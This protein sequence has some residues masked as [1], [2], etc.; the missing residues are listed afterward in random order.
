MDENDL[1]D[2]ADPDLRYVSITQDQLL[3]AQAQIASCMSC[4][5]EAEIPFDWLI[6]DVMS[7]RGYVDYIMPLPAKCPNCYCPI[8][9]KTLVQPEGGLEVDAFKTVLDYS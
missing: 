6:R 3:R 8:N 5:P 9:E 7:D 4:N 2:L 1:E